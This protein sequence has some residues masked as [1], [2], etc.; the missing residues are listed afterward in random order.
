MTPGRRPRV[1]LLGG[2]RRRQVDRQIL[3]RDGDPPARRVD[4]AG[5]RARPVVGDLDGERVAIEVA[6]RPVAARRAC[7]RPADRCRRRRGPATAS[8]RAV[9]EVH[10]EPVP[11]AAADRDEVAPLVVEPG[12]ARRRPGARRR[13]SGCPWRSSRSASSST[14]RPPRR[15][16]SSRRGRGAPVASR[17]PASGRGQARRASRP[18]RPRRRAALATRWSAP[19]APVIVQAGRPAVAG[20]DGSCPVSDRSKPVGCRR[21]RAASGRRAGPPRAAGRRRSGRRSRR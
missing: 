13:S 11:A 3:A 17:P 8:G 6:H 10:G 7:R 9:V 21:R 19:L 5:R 4:R 1:E 15:S 2:D 12:L 14:S 20:F 18:P 16:R